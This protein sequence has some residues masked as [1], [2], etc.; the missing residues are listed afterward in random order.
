MRIAEW[1]ED[2]ILKGTIC[3]GNKV[4]SQV[5]FSRAF[6]I[7]PITAAKGVSVLEDRGIVEKRRG[8]GM[9]VTAGAKDKIYAYRKNEALMEIIRDMLAEAKKLDLSEESLFEL[10]KKM[11]KEL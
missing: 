3:E 7:N 9:F 5:E 4:F 2:E 10:I 6:G 8:L 1:V 11:E